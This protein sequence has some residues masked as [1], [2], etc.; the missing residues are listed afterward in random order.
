MDVLSLIFAVVA[1]VI[2]ILAYQKTGG[3]ADLRKQIDQIASSA[4]LRKSVDSLTAAAE[5]L[6]EKTVEAIGKLEEIFRREGRVEKEPP[7]RRPPERPA[8]LKKRMPPGEKDFQSELDSV[9]ASAQQRGESLIEIKSGDLHRS[10][11]G[12]PGPN[13]RMTICCRVMKSNMKP[14]DEILQQPP[15]GQGATL[16]IGFKLPRGGKG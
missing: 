14:G 2:A 5:K 11:G 12:Y 10:V 8:E 7:E 13:H 15:S 6:R 1:L 3:V 9:F 4:D 16:I